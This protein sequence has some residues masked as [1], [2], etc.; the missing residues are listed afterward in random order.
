MTTC[1]T[2]SGVLGKN[3]FMPKLSGNF[4]DKTR[5]TI[6]PRT[7]TSAA[8]PIG[9]FLQLLLWFFLRHGQSVGTQIFVEP[10]LALV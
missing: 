2:S 10:Q 8:S 1:L 6:A 7:S 4:L 5:Y 9:E 3:L